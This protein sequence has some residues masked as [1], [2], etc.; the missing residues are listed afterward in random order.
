LSNPSVISSL[1]GLLDRYAIGSIAAR[2]GESEESITRGLPR[3]FAVILSGI[4]DKSS[5]PESSRKIFELIVNVPAGSLRESTIGNIALGGFG[6][7]PLF[8]G[9]ERL[10]SA[11][12]GSKE[13]SGAEATLQNRQVS[14]GAAARLLHMAAAMVLGVLAKRVIEDRIPFPRFAGFMSNEVDQLTNYLPASGE[15]GASVSDRSKKSAD[16]LL[17]ACA[18]TAL[19]LGGI[20]YLHGGAG[21]KYT[22]DDLQTTAVNTDTGSARTI[23]PPGSGPFVTRKLPDGAALEVPENGTEARLLDSIGNPVS[24]GEETTWID[25]DRL[26]FDPGSAL[27]RT[28]S[29]EQLRNVAAILQSYPNVRLKIGSFTDNTGDVKASARLSDNRAQAVKRELIAMGVDA[30]RLEAEGLGDRR[31]IAKDTTKPG[32]AKNRRISLRVLPI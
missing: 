19:L 17:A 20:W 31:P 11:V 24:P 21:K 4:F 12:F 5:D 1:E 29:E 13:R 26:S 18:L 28:E 3:A 2:T 10:L 22:A 30:G 23:R 8:D 9:G 25:F 27:P 7:A 16:W 32:R 15:G 14:A 6:A